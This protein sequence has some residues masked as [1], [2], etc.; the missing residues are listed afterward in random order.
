MGIVGRRPWPE[1]A[2]CLLVGLQLWLIV[3]H[4]AWRDELQAYLLVRDSHGVGGLF[5]DLHYEGHPS[6]W[7]LVLGPL[8]AVIQ[9]PMALKVA[10]VLVALAVTALIWLRAPFPPWLKLL[11]LAGY[12]PLF[13]YGVIARSY[14]LG[15]L[16]VFAWLVF[17]R[18]AWGWL[19]LALMANVAVNFA[20]LSGILVLAGLWIERRWS[21]AGVALWAI[22]GLAAV[23]TLFPAHDVSTG[24]LDLPLWVRW[25]EGLRRESAIL[26]PSLV[27]VWPYRWQVLVSPLESPLPAA[28]VGFVA[29]AV[30]IWSVARDR[31]ASVLMTVLFVVMTALSALIYPTYPRHVGVLLLLAIAMEWIRIEK[32]ADAVSPVFLGWMGVSAL[33]GLW[34]AVWALFVPFSYGRQEIDWIKAHH[35]QTARWAVYPG[36]VGSDIS[37]YLGPQT[38]NLQKGGCL[39]TFI[40]WDTHAYDDVDDDD[41]ADAIRQPGPFAYLAS[42]RDLSGL[43]A[44]LKLM[45]HF[46]RGLG[47]NGVFL[48]AVQR[49]AQG[50]AQVCP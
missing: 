12:F 14:G 28:V 40:R 42:D 13:E 45:A 27:G 24:A 43:N 19:I 7:Y 36:Y 50:A 37:A 38:Y 31:R 16:L 3:G 30:A 35:L 22:A 15:E 48:Y 5:A 4:V 44:P 26:L 18:T 8:Q 49:P 39:D 2:L 46:N 29:G 6:L 21:W 41:L 10:Q 11:I 32:A 47:D 9:S 23:A 17:R 1:F 25:I 33:C 34:A 20:F